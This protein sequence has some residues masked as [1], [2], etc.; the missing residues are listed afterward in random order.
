MCDSIMGIAQ[1]ISAQA[2][3]NTDSE[4]TAAIAVIDLVSIF[5]PLQQAWSKQL[6]TEA[7]NIYVDNLK[8]P[9]NPGGAAKVAADT[10]IRNVDS[11][12]SD[13][14][15]GN[16]DTIIQGQKAQSQILGNSMNTIYSLEDPVNEL[17]RAQTDALQQMV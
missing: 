14:E 4:L 7:E 2:D 9:G 10:Q 16:L 15:T 17:L 5:L 12:N 11:T 13:M 6:S 3:A 8:V 1:G